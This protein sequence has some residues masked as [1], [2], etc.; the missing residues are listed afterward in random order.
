MKSITHIDSA[1]LKE[2]MSEIMVNSSLQHN[3]IV[4]F[5]YYDIEELKGINN[6]PLNKYN[7]YSYI[8]LMDGDLAEELAHRKKNN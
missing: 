1:L 2:T 6:K 7:L 5:Y 8:E 4:R 3:H